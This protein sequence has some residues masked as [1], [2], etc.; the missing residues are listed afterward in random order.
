MLGAPEI[1]MIAGGIA[2]LFGAKKLPELARSLGKA[3]TEFRKGLSESDT[4]A[5]AEAEKGKEKEKVAKPD[6]P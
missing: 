2:L 5:A 6:Q 4:E 1:M 3:K